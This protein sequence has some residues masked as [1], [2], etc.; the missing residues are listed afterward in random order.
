MVFGNSEEFVQTHYEEVQRLP[1]YPNS[2]SIE[3]I[4]GYLVVKIGFIA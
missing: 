1:I 2:G 4:D 3:Y